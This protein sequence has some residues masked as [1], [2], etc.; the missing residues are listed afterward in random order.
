MTSMDSGSTAPLLR[1]QSLAIN[2]DSL[3]VARHGRAC[4]SSTSVT[5]DRHRWHICPTQQE[6]SAAH[7]GLMFSLVPAISAALI[8]LNGPAAEAPRM[9]IGVVV[10]DSGDHW[11]CCLRLDYTSRLRGLEPPPSCCWPQHWCSCHACI[12]VEY[13]RSSTISACPNPASDAISTSG[14]TWDRA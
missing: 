6:P 8:L 14:K 7:A 11:G 12:T 4:V 13:A 5:V 1:T 2:T 3:S 9:D 10:C